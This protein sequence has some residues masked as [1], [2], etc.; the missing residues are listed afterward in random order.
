[1][2]SE[3]AAGFNASFESSFRTPAGKAEIYSHNYITSLV[4]TDY[5]IVDSEN[6][7]ASSFC[8]MLNFNCSY[9]DIFL[10]RNSGGD[11]LINAKILEDN[12]N[13]P[14]Q[15]NILGECALFADIN[16][17]PNWYQLKFSFIEF[18]ESKTY[19]LELS[20]SGDTQLKW[21]TNS[22][23][24]LNLILNDNTITQATG[25]LIKTKSLNTNS[26]VF[27]IP[28]LLSYSINSSDKLGND[29][30]TIKIANTNGYYDEG[31]PLRHLLI[32][33]K[34]IQLSISNGDSELV[35]CTLLVDSHIKGSTQN[36]IKLL[37]K[38]SRLLGQEALFKSSYIGLDYSEIVSD[39]IQQSGL[40]VGNTIYADTGLYADDGL[41]SD[42]DSGTLNKTDINF[43]QNGTLSGTIADCI[44]KIEQATNHVFKFNNLGIP[45]LTPRKTSFEPEYTFSQNSTI[46]RQ[47][48]T[49]NES[50][51]N[52]FNRVLITNDLTSDGNQLNI[53]QATELEEYTGTLDANT[54][55]LDITHDYIT[56]P[57]VRADIKNTSET[58]DT[59][60]K[61]LERSTSSITIRVQNLNYPNSSGDYSF[62][63]SGSLVLNSQDD[64][65][66]SEK[67]RPSPFEKDSVIDY[68][69]TNSLFET[70][71][72]LDDYAQRILLFNSSAREFFDVQTRGYPSIE[73]GDCVQFDHPS[74]NEEFI[75]KITGQE[76]QYK[77]EPRQYL[78]RYTC[79]KYPFLKGETIDTLLNAD[80]VRPD[81]ITY[82]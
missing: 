60:L 72:Q 69:L 73:N 54:R 66:I 10:S 53:D 71:E 22:D 19:W 76:I 56:S 2:I 57:I 8:P 23:T 45:K 78:T 49:I 17:R 34:E 28:S 43:P 21:Y 38:Y 70:T 6:K 46:L 11:D 30:A 50:K 18:E 47:Q 58:D 9:I 80:G 52:L 15:D 25:A 75:Y 48:L 63:I 40:N 42:Q 64:L 41:F 26:N 44:S 29:Q 32:Q 14:D 35:L 39:L 5:V 31:Q 27:E 7:I 62:S 20:C 36:T 68:T 55:Y 81:Q 74:V 51:K 13:A 61:E 33:D 59:S 4:K 37:G 16:R 1:M 67:A 24:S 82:V 12:E 79:E 65:L 3:P 77:N